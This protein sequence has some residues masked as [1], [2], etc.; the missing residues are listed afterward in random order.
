MSHYERLDA[1]DPVD[2]AAVLEQMQLDLAL[3]NQRNSRTVLHPKLAE[4][5]DKNGVETKIACICHY[6]DTILQY[7]SEIEPNPTNNLPRF[8][9]EH[10]R[11]DWQHEQDMLVRTGKIKGNIATLPGLKGRV[12]VE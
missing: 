12:G 1:P 11:D 2:Q 9:D 3:Q 10:C 8:C 4:V 5:K 7:I 6:C